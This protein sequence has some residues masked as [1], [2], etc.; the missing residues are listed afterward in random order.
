MTKGKLSREE[1]VQSLREDLE[2]LEYIYA[3]WEGDS[4]G[5]NRT[6]EWSD[7]DL[8]LLADDERIKETF[9]A[10]ERS[11]ETLSPILH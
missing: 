7:L 3:C 1:I 5:F 11:M 4:V 6:D 8:Y 10:V 2:P 9:T